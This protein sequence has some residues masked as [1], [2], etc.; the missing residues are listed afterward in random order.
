MVSHTTETLLT[1][2]DIGATLHQG[3]LTLYNDIKEAVASYN[4]IV[5]YPGSI[6]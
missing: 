2:C 3:K 5:N 6:H 1:Y 4:E